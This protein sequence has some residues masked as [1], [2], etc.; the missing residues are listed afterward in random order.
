MP[1]PAVFAPF[2]IGSSADG[3][4]L[5]VWKHTA[6]GLATPIVLRP[7]LKRANSALEVIE[8]L[9]AKRERHVGFAS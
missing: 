9:A 2:G 1:A 4:S 5:D 3:A 7:S 8:E 6:K